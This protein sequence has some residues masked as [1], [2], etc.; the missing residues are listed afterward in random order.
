MV[1][2]DVIN[3]RLYRFDMQLYSSQSKIF[4]FISG[5]PRDQIAI[6]LFFIQLSHLAS[7]TLNEKARSHGKLNYILFVFFLF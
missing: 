1:F 3:C 2:L 4:V 6:S 7:S 5:P